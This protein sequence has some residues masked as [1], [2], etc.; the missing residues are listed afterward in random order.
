MRRGV[1]PHR[2]SWLVWR[3]TAE[4]ALAAALSLAG[5]VAAAHG[6][7][8]AF[9]LAAFGLGIA[10]RS[11]WRGWWLGAAVVAELRWRAILA[12]LIRQSRHRRSD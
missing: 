4:L 6:S 9:V 12:R 1:A 10:G 3:L 2:L 5:V 11:A 8:W 7:W